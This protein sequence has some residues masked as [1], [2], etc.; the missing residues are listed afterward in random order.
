MDFLNLLKEKNILLTD[1]QIHQI[2]KTLKIYLLKDTI[3]Y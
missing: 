1:Y 3:N 2:R